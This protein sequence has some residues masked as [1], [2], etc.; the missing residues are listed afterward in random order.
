MY[1]FCV[2]FVR[3]LLRAL[4][5]EATFSSRSVFLSKETSRTGEPTITWH[6]PV[7][8]SRPEEFFLSFFIVTMMCQKGNIGADFKCS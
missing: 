6:T 3:V 7:I 2:L 1:L 8:Q 5:L 4:L